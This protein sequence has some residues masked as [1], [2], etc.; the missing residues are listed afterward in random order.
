MGFT[1]AA[2]QVGYYLE[3]VEEEA[4]KR[5]HRE[6]EECAELDQVVRYGVFVYD[7]LVEI[8]ESLR[9]EGELVEPHVSS[10]RECFERWLEAC[11][12]LLPVASDFERRGHV[13]DHAA[14][15]RKRC[16]EARW[17]LGRAE[18]VLRSEKVT[19]LR[20]AALADEAAGRTVE[21]GERLGA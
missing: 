18:D 11:E 7:V 4:W 3:L 21:V 12:K 10:I 2:R 14:A 6:A 17:S 1:V 16:S 5:D 8:D 20:D 9:L 13:V 19:A 15:L